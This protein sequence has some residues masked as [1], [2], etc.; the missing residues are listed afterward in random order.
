MPH[1]TCP[2]CSRSM[3]AWQA[4]DVELDHCTQCKG[5]W[6]DANELSRHLFNISGSGLKVAATE[7]VQTHLTCPRCGTGQ[8]L[9]ATF[10][11]DVAVE[12]CSECGGIF[13]DLGELYDLLGALQPPD[14]ASNP[15]SSLS[16]F[17]SFAL[18]LFVGMRRGS[19]SS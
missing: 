6:F 15:N 7:P 10:F 1:L 8:H 17:D 5:L 16:G 18:G 9:D 11:H 14:R 4:G 13:L 12:S 2:K 3:S 19:K